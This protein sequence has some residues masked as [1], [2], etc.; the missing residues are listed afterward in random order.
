M[1]VRFTAGGTMPT[2]SRLVLREAFVTDGYDVNLEPWHLV[3]QGVD[4]A[5]HWSLGLE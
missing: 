5:V 1:S 4:L 2:D 3:S